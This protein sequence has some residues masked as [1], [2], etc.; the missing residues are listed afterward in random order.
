MQ[1]VTE[2]QKTLLVRRFP[3]VSLFF[4]WNFLTNSFLVDMVPFEKVV[5]LLS[6]KT[7]DTLFVDFVDYWT[8]SSSEIFKMLKEHLSGHI[9]KVY[10]LLN[11]NNT[12]E[13]R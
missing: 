1:Q 13:T 4:H 8:K 9:V 2:L 7:S 12:N 10:Q 5:Q 11:C 6:M 3:I